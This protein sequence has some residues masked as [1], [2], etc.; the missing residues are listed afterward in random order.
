ME[1]DLIPNTAFAD[2]TQLF[3]G[4][5]FCLPLLQNLVFRLFFN[6][7]KLVFLFCLCNYFGI[8]SSAICVVF[9]NNRIILRKYLLSIYDI[10]SVSAIWYFVF[11]CFCILVFLVCLSWLP[12]EM[13]R[14]SLWVW[15]W[16]ERIIHTRVM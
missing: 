7:C 9:W 13:I 11:R 3:F 1:W 12:K 5:I 2:P 16:M 14:F 6:L 10:C 8:S 15:G 4:V